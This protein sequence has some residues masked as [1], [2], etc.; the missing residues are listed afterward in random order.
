M[1]NTCLCQTR[2]MVLCAEKRAFIIEVYFR[3]SSYK[4]VAE[5]YAEKFPDSPLP[6]K[7]SIKRIVNHFQTSWSLE[8]KKKD[9][10]ASVLTPAKMKEIS[11][12][13][14]TKMDTSVR[15]LAR[16]TGIKPTSAF[17][18][19]KQLKLHPYRATL[20]QELK[21]PD[22]PR[23]L[24]FCRWLLNFVRTHGVTT[25]DRVYFSDEA[26]F[27]RTGYINA[28]NYRFW[29]SNNPHV[30]R[31]SSLHP[32]KIGVWCAVS[33]RRVV[34]P[35]FFTSTVT[36]E[37]YQDIIM[38]FVA[39]LEV[40]D[41]NCWFQQDGASAHSCEETLSFLTEFFQDQ[42]ISI[43]RT[44]EWPPRS[45]DLSPPDFFLWAYLKNFVFTEAVE[46]VED[47]KQRITAGIA[48]ITPKMLRN[49]SRNLVKRAQ[50]CR[51]AQGGHFQHFL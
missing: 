7:S 49:V 26:W 47:L 4:I 45:P 51:S 50:I 34:G 38:Q 12:K 35:I 22:L 24:R 36:A 10:P 17:R 30:F 21:P 23:R 20:V 48:T 8:P 27:H 3:S 39:L 46:S 32:Q 1:V 41:R 31:E 28:R 15:K 2:S 29:S 40:E 43:K 44:P 33:R 14:D 19:L 11:T 37:V 6:S 16:Q 13:M 5:R 9:R 18:A 42:I 25:L